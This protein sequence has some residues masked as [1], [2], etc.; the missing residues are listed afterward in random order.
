M[1]TSEKLLRGTIVHVT[2]YEQSFKLNLCPLSSFMFLL[3]GDRKQLHVYP[4]TQN[5]YIRS[6]PC[7]AARSG[8]R[9]LRYQNCGW[10]IPIRFR[11]L[12]AKL[13]IYSPFLGTGCLP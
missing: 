11:H 12:R 5:I 1:P 6:H 10:A 2:C 4:L 13:D 3:T 8:S 7:G 9:S